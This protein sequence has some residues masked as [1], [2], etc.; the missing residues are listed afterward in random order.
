MAS[1]GWI[2]K[3][4]DNLFTRGCSHVS[5]ISMILRLSG[6]SLPPIGFRPTTKE[7]ANGPPRI[8]VFATVAGEWSD[9]TTCVHMKQQLVLNTGRRK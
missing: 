2:L 3:L 7:L 5:A 9:G 8:R 1:R 6:L 4:A